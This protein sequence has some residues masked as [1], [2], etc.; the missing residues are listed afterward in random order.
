MDGGIITTHIMDN[1]YD[2]QTVGNVEINCMINF[3]SRSQGFNFKTLVE[4]KFVRFKNSVL[5]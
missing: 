4:D 2:Q 5:R 3:V 1:G